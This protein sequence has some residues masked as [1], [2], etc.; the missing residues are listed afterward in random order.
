MG[1][2]TRACQTA[3]EQFCISLCFVFD[4]ETL[5]AEQGDA[6]R[7]QPDELA[8]YASATPQQRPLC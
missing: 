4:G 3:S 7:L 5:T 8:S 2:D 6:I 1:Y